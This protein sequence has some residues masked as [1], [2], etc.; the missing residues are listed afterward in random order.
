MGGGHEVEFTNEVL[1]TFKLTKGK[2]LLQELKV[3][4]AQTRSAGIFPA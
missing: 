4:I 1:K 2:A 3:Q